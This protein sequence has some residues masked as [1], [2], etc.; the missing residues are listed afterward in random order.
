MQEHQVIQTSI[1]D[2]YMVLTMMPSLF[3]ELRCP[4]CYLSLEDR[5]NPYRMAPDDVRATCE[6]IDNYY[7][8][9]QVESKKIVLYW[10]GG[11][12]TSMPIEYF[13]ELI[14]TINGVFTKEK[15]Y[16]TSHVVLSSL[17]N[18]SPK[19]YDF[20]KKYCNGSIQTSYDAQMRGR[21]YI[22]DWELKVREA[23]FYGLEVTTISV[24]NSEMLKMGAIKTTEYLNSLGIKDAGFLPFMLNEQNKGKKY[25]TFAPSMNNWSQFMIELSTEY[26]RLKSEGKNTFEIGQLHFIATM[27]QRDDP[28]SN[29]AAQTLFFM[30]NGDLSLPD[31]KNGYEEFLRPF[32]NAIESEKFEDIL[33]SPERLAYLTKQFTRNFNPECLSCEYSNRCVMEFWKE[34]RE[35]DDC[36]GGSKYVKWLDD[37]KAMFP[38]I[39]GN[40]EIS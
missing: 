32:G 31:Y 30:P 10:Y 19:W 7:S 37:N 14:E 39:S 1:E 40:A 28:I 16:T 34:N 24:L 26:A 5:K 27:E 11:E 29:I 38:T 15:G 23:Q 18:I 22:R 2:G 21:K 20:I 4:H 9:K 3:C 6:K 17:I 35:G 36:F 33:N 8:R 25:D 12:P 13:E